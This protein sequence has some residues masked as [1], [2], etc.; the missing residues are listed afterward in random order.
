MAIK[1]TERIAY[2]YKKSKVRV[3]EDGEVI[4]DSGDEVEVDSDNEMV[5]VA[6]LVADN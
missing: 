2:G 6:E 5:D 3:D 4:E 1:E